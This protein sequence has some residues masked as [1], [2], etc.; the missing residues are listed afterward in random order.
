ML[1]AD[2]RPYGFDTY[3]LFWVRSEHSM[4]GN[5]IILLE[6]KKEK[7]RNDEY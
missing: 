3:N 1:L 7:N 6:K 4:A 5:A 2:F